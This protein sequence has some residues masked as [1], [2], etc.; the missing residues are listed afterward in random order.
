MTETTLQLIDYCLGF[1]GDGP[2]SLRY[3]EDWGHQP[4]TSSEIL[5]V[6]PHVEEVYPKEVT[7][8]IPVNVDSF[9]REVVRDFV[10]AGRGVDYNF[11]HF[12]SKE[13]REIFTTN[14]DDWR[15]QLESLREE[16][17]LSG[18]DM[19]KIWAEII[20]PSKVKPK[21]FGFLNN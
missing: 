7:N 21:W 13:E 10:L 1:Y 17:E 11:E 6:L 8:G 14:A 19:G 16:K 9:L 15:D 18:K 4:M 12:T 20:A 5:A 3:L 2:D